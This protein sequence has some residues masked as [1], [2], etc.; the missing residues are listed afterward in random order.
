MP[1]LARL[2]GERLQQPGI[3]MTKGVDGN[4]CPEVQVSLAIL[5]EKVR[6]LATDEGDIRPV[7]G[8]KQSREHDKNSSFLW[9][10]GSRLTP[11]FRLK[12]KYKSRLEICVYLLSVTLLQ[13]RA[14][15]RSP[16]PPDG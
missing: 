4:S 8:G 13:P 9:A 5:S 12:L 7:I 14:W 2:V 16:A 11:W 1:Q 3:G 15:H 6:T 10:V